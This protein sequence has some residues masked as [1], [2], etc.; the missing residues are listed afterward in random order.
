MVGE[1]Y[2][3]KSKVGNFEGPLGLLLS[4]IEEKKLFI[5]DLSLA[6]VTE[7][8]LAYVKNLQEAPAEKR[9]A[10]ISYF[11]LIEHKEYHQQNNIN[12]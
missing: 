6:E 8:Y 10:D 9:I 3:Y 2:T 7:D 5:N 1:S 11:I 4:L 12:N